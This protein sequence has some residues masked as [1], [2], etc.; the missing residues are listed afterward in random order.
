M[1]IEGDFEVNYF[2]KWFCTFTDNVIFLIAYIKI[3]CLSGAVK[4]ITFPQ[5]FKNTFIAH[6]N[7]D[8]IFKLLFINNLYTFAFFLLLF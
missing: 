1:I 2:M 7:N 8:N 3:A 6:V 4:I 5:N